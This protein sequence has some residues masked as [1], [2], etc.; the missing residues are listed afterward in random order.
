MFLDLH[1]IELD[2][3]IPDKILVI[4]VKYIY[5]IMCNLI[6]T[7]NRRELLSEHISLDI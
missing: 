2:H 6:I 1:L 7:Q 4:W 3:C 5:L